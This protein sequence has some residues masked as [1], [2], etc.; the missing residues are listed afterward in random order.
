MQ[1][2]LTML[3]AVFSM[4]LPIKSSSADGFPELKKVSDNIYAIVGE[5]VSHASSICLI[6]KHSQEKMRF[7]FLMKWSGND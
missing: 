4:L 1:T 7:R 2:L 6:S 3:V 5:L